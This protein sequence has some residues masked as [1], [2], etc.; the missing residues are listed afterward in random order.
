MLI[1]KLFLEK[2]HSIKIDTDAYTVMGTLPLNISLLDESCVD[3][4][5]FIPA[6]GLLKRAETCTVYQQVL[7]M[8]QQR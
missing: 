3:D 7:L 6:M 5:L 4:H 1:W 8:T 2:V